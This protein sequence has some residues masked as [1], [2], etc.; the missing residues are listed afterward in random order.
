MLASS[1]L[2]VLH[3]HSVYSLGPCGYLCPR[4]SCLQLSLPISLPDCELLEPRGFVCQNPQSPSVQQVAHG[5]HSVSS[6]KNDLEWTVSR[7]R[8]E[9]GQPLFPVT[10]KRVLL[11]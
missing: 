8:L 2:V 10:R 6:T 1:M 9:K 7:G 11:W 5:K 3:A 4:I